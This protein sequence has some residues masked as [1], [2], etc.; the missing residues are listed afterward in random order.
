MNFSYQLTSEGLLGDSM[1]CC[2]PEEF[3]V[4]MKLP[5]LDGPNTA[6][7]AAAMCGLKVIG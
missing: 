1:Y 4:W 3:V 6:A 2:T 5:G 7:A